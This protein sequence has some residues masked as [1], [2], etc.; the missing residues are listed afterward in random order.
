MLCGQPSSPR[1]EH[2]R[3]AA[4]GRPGQDKRVIDVSLGEVGLLLIEHNT[5]RSAIVCAFV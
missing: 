3:L 2:Q 5:Q 4:A 1:C